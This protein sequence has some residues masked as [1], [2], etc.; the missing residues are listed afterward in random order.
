M[1][2]FKKYLPSVSRDLVVIFKVILSGITA[3]FLIFFISAL[4]GVDLKKNS[5]LISELDRMN[6][7]INAELEGG[8]ERR[9]SALG[10][11]PAINPFKKYYCAEYAKEIH[12]ISYLSEKQKILF[13]TFNVREFEVKAQ[14][15]VK[16]AENANIG[17]LNNELEIVK[18][19]LKNSDN[20]IDK[21][22]ATLSRQRIAYIVFFFILWI[23][24]YIYY[25]RGIIRRGVKIP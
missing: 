4:A 1:P 13:D 10:E 3:A 20:L 24:V 8:I 12:D 15:L 6:A 25:S 21:R 14:Q 17:S 2:S 18:R 11:V 7:Q 5:D 22:R 16:F 23:I 9:I 19:E